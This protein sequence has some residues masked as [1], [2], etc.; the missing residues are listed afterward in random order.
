MFKKKNDGNGEKIF[1]YSIRKYHF[2][3]AS[4]AVAALMFFANGVQAQAPA[5]SSA[6]ASD[7][8]AESAGTPDKDKQ[9]S[10]GEEPEKVSQT[11][12]SAELQ[13]TGESNSPETKIEDASKG[14]ETADLAPTKPEAKPAAQETSQSE[15]E[16][17]QDQPT[18]VTKTTEAK[19]LQGNL[20]ALLEKLTLSSMKAL[21]DEVESRLAA[22]KAVL[23]DPKA[24]QAQVDEQVRAM[25]ELTSRVNQALEPS[26]PKLTDLG[27]ASSTNNKLSAP[28]GA[29]TE[30]ASSGKRRKRGGPIDLEPAANQVSPTDAGKEAAPE[31]NSQS[32]P[33]ELPTY[34][35]TTE[36]E[37]GAYG[38]KKELEDITKELRRYGASED[39][40]Q[41]AKAAADKFNEAFSKGDT[42]SQED[43]A[44]ALVD[45]KKSRDLIEG[46]LEEK[47][48]EETTGGGVTPQPRD[49]GEELPSRGRGRRVGRATRDGSNTYDTSREYYIEDGKK[50]IS[51][52]DKYTYVFYSSR[53]SGVIHDGVNRLVKEGRDFIYAD[54]TPIEN[55][56]RWDVYINAA[57]YD[58][59][60]SVGWFTVPKGSTV[61]NGTVNIS[62]S[63]NNGNHATSPNDGTIASALRKAGLKYVTKGTTKASGVQKFGNQSANKSFN[64]ANLRALATT[65]GVNGNNPYKYN[66]LGSYPQ[67]KTLVEDKLTAIDNNNGDLYYFEQNADRTAYHLS[68]ETTGDTDVKRLVYAVGMKGDRIDTTP[69]IPVAVRFIANQWY[70]KTSSENTYADQYTPTITYPTYIVKQGEYKN[71]AYGHNPNWERHPENTTALLNYDSHP[72]NKANFDANNYYYFKNDA[73]ESSEEILRKANEKGFNDNFKIF[74]SDGREISKREMGSTGADVPGMHEYTWKW[75]FR[76]GS[77]STKRVKFAVIPQKP[78]FNQQLKFIGETQDITATANGGAKASGVTMVLYREHTVNGRNVTEQ[79]GDPVAANFQGK[80]TFS[81]VTI[82]EGKYY[83]RTVIKTDEY[84]DYQGNKHKTL[85]SDPVNENEKLVAVEAPTVK[86]NGKKLTTNADD[87]RFIIYRGAVFNPTFRVENDGKQVNSLKASGIPKG[88][89]FN[90]VNGG[91]QPKTNMAHGSEY[92]ISTNNVVDSDTRLGEGTATVTVVNHQGKSIDYK[93][94]YIVADVQ[95]QNTTENKLVGDTIGNPH[96]FVKA[97]IGNVEGNR[98]FP[99]GISFKWVTNTLTLP[100]NTEKLGK[101]GRT[102]NYNVQVIFPHNGPFEKTIDWAKYTIYAP[103]AK[104]IPV[105]FNVTDNVAPTVKLG[106][107]NGGTILTES[108]SNAPEITIYKGANFTDTIK[109]FDNESRGIVNLKMESGLPN[110]L[111]LEGRS[112]I[113]KTSATE[114]REA[115]VN[116]SGE[117]ATN[118]QLGVQIVNLKVSDD[119]SGNVDRGNTK[120]VKFKVKVL[121]LAFESRGK[122]I[123]ENT[124]SDTLGLNQTSVDANH[125]LTVTD[126]V[127]KRD[128]FPQG[129]IFRYILA[130]GTIKNTLRFDKPGK[131]TVTAAAYYPKGEK[132]VAGAP[133]ASTNLKGEGVAEIAGRPY[134]TKQIIFEVKPTAP[135]VA[136]QDNGDVTITQRNETNVNRL[137]VTYTTQGDNPE[138]VTYTASKNGDTWSFGSNVPIT[139]DGTT[140]T[141]KIKDRLVQDGST[142]RVK[143]IVSGDTGDVASDEA[144]GDARQGDALYPTINFQN[145]ETDAQGNR[146]VY[147]TPTETTNLDVATVNDNSKKLLEAVFFDQGAKV[148]DLGNY[149]IT[150]NKVT[151]NGDTITN[152][153]YTLTVTGILNR[154]KSANTLW[155]DGDVITT[156]YASAVDAAENNIK[157]K[158]GSR[159]DNASNP[160]RIVFKVRTQAAKY[161]PTANT[162]TRNDQQAKHTNDQVLGAVSGTN[163]AAKEIVGNIPNESGVAVVKVTYNDGS[164]ENVNVPINVTPTDATL[165]TPQVTNLTR[166]DQQPKHTEDQVKGAVTGENIQSKELLDPIPTGSGDVRVKVTYKDGSSE[167][168]TVPIEVTASQAAPTPRPDNGANTN[169][170]STTIPAD[171]N[172]NSVT[173]GNSDNTLAP[174]VT[175]DDSSNTT[176]ATSSST[177]GQAQASTPAH[178]EDSTDQATGPSAQQRGAGN[179]TEAE[180]PRGLS[181]SSVTAPARSRRSVAFAGGAQ[182]SQEK[183]VDKSV[184]RD[185]IQDLETRL[186]DLDG[187]DQSVIDAAKVILGEGQEALRNADLTEAGLKEMTAKVKEALESLKGKQATKDE[188]EMQETRKEQGHLP[189]GTMIA[190]LLALLGLLLFLIA[191][192]KKE[193]ELKKLTK[194][195]TKVLQE[196]DLTNVD[197]KVLDKAREALAQAVAFLAN[198]KE[199][200]HTEDELIEKLKAILAQLR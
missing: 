128:M 27:E 136:P 135:V 63:D 56:F 24:T 125:Y 153:P 65:G 109:V 151:R 86:I 181:E 83:V 129:M 188:E 180:S 166:H 193:S 5:V 117:I 64:S 134:L 199:S 103:S 94:K 51:S 9:E 14:Q 138:E 111:S 147:I 176:S 196:S 57:R 74:K 43:F 115:T 190:S 79:I 8:V 78:N 189:Y 76:D 12:P 52:Y 113:Q 54:V 96:R 66:I 67:D 36:G 97:T 187:I 19:S 59:S 17:E 158:S 20:Q 107:G 106:T 183:Q 156:R 29:V 197:A 127:N 50:G 33:R 85:E 102:T 48:G 101:A 168:V 118:A 145:E 132:S 23:D 161:T 62:W 150:Y 60:D 130:D 192:R 195:L 1:R 4:V 112:A 162:L 114:G 53:Q 139:I 121:D 198:E 32:T 177:V 159:T 93:F 174:S 90:K 104:T 46:V 10:D 88:V 141:V 89:W 133:I 11:E 82:Q 142:V 122:A 35:N 92:T 70:A 124:H 28:D 71:Q 172:S 6:T 95:G 58:L 163:I 30:Q 77:V 38:L 146:V 61:K 157:D 154:E 178:S 119:A 169:N 105:I 131:Y 34:T 160:Y 16:K 110:G 22:A 200:D 44:A 68:F 126:G 84:R 40:I 18:S 175:T 75:T 7:V 152:A 143:A 165:I 123:N 182:S 41:A 15:R 25:E 149:G 186:K 171:S 45:L 179:A 148:T 137:S 39:K 72:Y 31:A 140:G 2:G 191:R 116:I 155:N 164:T 69:Q 21:H 49:G 55:G 98:Y 87:N 185:L 184:L 3:A 26:L 91:D 80:A 47:Y 42:I 37:N 108:E 173:P 167:E 73:G 100:E 99:E 120:T 144:S 13:S 194:E 81:N 170:D